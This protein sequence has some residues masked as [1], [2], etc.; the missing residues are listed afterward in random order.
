MKV[1]DQFQL[2]GSRT[3]DI[4]LTFRC[5]RPTKY[6]LHKA[7]MLKPQLCGRLFKSSDPHP[8]LQITKTCINYLA[9]PT[10]V[11]L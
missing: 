8:L 4:G 1:P 3:R 11:E 7:A 6:Q 9:F 2:K 5:T 10:L